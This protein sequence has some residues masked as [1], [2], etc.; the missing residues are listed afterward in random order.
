MYLLVSLVFFLFFRHPAPDA[1]K[2][3]VWVDDIQVGEAVSADGVQSHIELLRIKSPW[4]RKIVRPWLAPQVDKLSRMDPQLLINSVF[5]AVERA[6]PAA[7]FLFLPLLAGAMKILFW[8]LKGLYFDH[9]IFALHFQTFFFLTLTTAYL[10]RGTPFFMYV[11]IAALAATPFY[12]GVALRTMWEQ[13]WF[14]IA[15]KTMVLVLAYIYLGGLV[16]ACV[17]SYTVMML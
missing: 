7:L 5:G 6:I 15:V 14:W 11:M 3:E 10:F 2:T 16:Y 12:L 13:G 1:S 4:L 8:R 17:V 9:L